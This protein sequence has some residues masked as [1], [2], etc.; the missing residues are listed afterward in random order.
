[1]IYTRLQSLSHLRVHT[2]AHQTAVRAQRRQGQLAHS[3][4]MHTFLQHSMRHTS[5]N[6]VGIT[7]L[8]P[9]AVTNGHMRR[10]R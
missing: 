6:Q 3:C 5:V 7:G 9:T 10:S 4:H 8:R 1:M 2:H